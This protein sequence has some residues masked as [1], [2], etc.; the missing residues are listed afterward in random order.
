VHWLPRANGPLM[1]L[2]GFAST[3]TAARYIAL[4][5]AFTLRAGDGNRT[6]TVSLGS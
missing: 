6:R 5:W 4:T 3:R 1:V 2:N